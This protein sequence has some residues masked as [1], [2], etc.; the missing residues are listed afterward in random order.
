[1]RKWIVGLL[2]TAGIILLISPL[3]KYQLIDFSA[4]KVS[5]DQYSAEELQQNNEKEATFDYEAITPPTMTNVLSSSVNMDD[6]AVIGVITIP[7]VDIELPILKGTTNANLLI[8]A[9]TMR[10][11]Q[12]MGQGN[13][14]LA[15]HHTRSKDQFFGHVPELKKG[16]DIYVTDKKNKYH[17][18]VTENKIISE[19]ETDVINDTTE[20]KIT[21]ITCDVPTKTNK[22]VMVQ[23]VLVE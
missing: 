22:R 14:A 2:F 17:Y 16:A 23:G 9:A 5:V 18:K 10:P 11:D 6:P 8:G 12:Q 4:S 15:G 20:N 1:M 13:Y 19:T 21:L 3:I 7:D